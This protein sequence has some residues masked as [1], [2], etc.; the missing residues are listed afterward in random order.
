M[1]IK[2]SIKKYRNIVLIG[3]LAVNILE[4][5]CK[6]KLVINYLVYI[7][8]LIILFFVSVIAVKAISRGIK[9]KKNLNN[10]DDYHDKYNN[11]KN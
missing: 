3:E 7:V 11:K 9:A 5:K 4:I 6:D 1:Q 10:K 8:I 2:F